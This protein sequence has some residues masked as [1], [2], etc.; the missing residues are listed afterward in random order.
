MATMFLVSFYHSGPVL[1]D[2]KCLGKLVSFSPHALLTEA[3]V[4][5]GGLLPPHQGWIV[6]D[7]K[8]AT[9]PGVGLCS[10]PPQIK[11]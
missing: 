4:L 7:W 6:V 10:G 8:V 11:P 9:N 3:P 1:T 2:G 5:G